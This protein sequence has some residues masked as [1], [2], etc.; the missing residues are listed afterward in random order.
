MSELMNRMIAGRLEEAARLLQEDGAD[1]V[2]VRAYTQ[3]ASSVRHWPISMAVMYRHR[4][5]EG[6]EEA[7]PAPREAGCSCVRHRPCTA[8]SRGIAGRG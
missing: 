8:D 5:V 3:A 4:G 6:L 1:P 7:R 2:Y